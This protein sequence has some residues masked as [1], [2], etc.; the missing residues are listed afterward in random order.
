MN[1]GEKNCRT[2]ISKEPTFII[3][4]FSANIVLKIYSNIKIFPKKIEILLGE[5]EMGGHD[6]DSKEERE[7]EARNKELKRL[8]VT[9]NGH[10]ADEVG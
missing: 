5:E 2:G 1:A 7:R 6:G 3:S 4:F 10:L 8:R 9:G